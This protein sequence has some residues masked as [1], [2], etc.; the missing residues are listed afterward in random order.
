MGRLRPFHQL[1]QPERRWAIQ[2]GDGF[3]DADI[4]C[5]RTNAAAPAHRGMDGRPNDS[6]GRLPRHEHVEQLSDEPGPDR[7]NVLPRNGHVGLNR[8]GR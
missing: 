7:R 4:Y 5:E 8:Y 2:P 6:M 1:L 3:L